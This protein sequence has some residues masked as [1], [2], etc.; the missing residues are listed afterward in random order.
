MLT[1]LWNKLRSLAEPSNC[2]GVAR[3]MSCS[4]DKDIALTIDV[5]SE[6]ESGV[7]YKHKVSNSAWEKAPCSSLLAWMTLFYKSI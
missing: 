1:A 4:K 2:S 3:G 7:R 5:E 6:I